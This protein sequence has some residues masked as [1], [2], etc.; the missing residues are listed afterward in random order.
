MKRNR[1]LWL[2][3]AV[4]LM[5]AGLLAYRAVR[6]TPVPVYVVAQA[7]LVQ[8]V[9]ATGR[10]SAV[11]NTQVGTEITG[12]VQAVQVS[13]GDHV[14]PGDTLLTLRSDDQ[15]ARVREAQA[16]LDALTRSRLPQAEA[17]LRQALA[18]LDQARREAD[19]RRQLLQARA[20]PKESKEQADQALA[21]ALASV[22]Q[23][24]LEVQSL[25]L[26]QTEEIILRERLAAARAALDKTVL[27][28]QSAGEVLRRDVEPGD[29]V[30][31]GKVLLELARDTGT[32]VRVPV[33]ERNLGVL[34]VG[35]K[36]WCVP[37]AWPDSRFQA[38][39]R[40]IA[41]TIDPQRGTVEIKL[42]IIDPPTYLRHDMTVT[43]TI[44]TGRV[45]Q[46]LIVPNQALSGRQANQARVLLVQG[47]QAQERIVTLGLRGL[48]GTQVLQGLAPG[49]QVILDP[50]IAVGQRVVP[51]QGR[52]ALDAQGATRRETPMKFN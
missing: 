25:S 40:E 15:A 49:D 41:P 8:Y 39:V 16:A 47:G 1:L 11:S 22:E 28:A 17:R 23:L 43:T 4:A 18:Q 37:D 2:V 3:L 21:T 34:A 6:G 10:V 52:V 45:D 33:D 5:V 50:A 14:Q 46:A 31:P 29:L 12:I 9:V 27:R 51:V 20:I 38:I 24:Q 19:R 32:E 30:Q 26:G 36:A 35:Q 44:E 7:P 48:A 13:E 42:D